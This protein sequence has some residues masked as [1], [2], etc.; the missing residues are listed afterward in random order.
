MSQRHRNEQPKPDLK[1]AADELEDLGEEGLYV[2]WLK[3]KEWW[4][5][6]GHWVLLAVLVV[7]SV[8]AGK[9]WLDV[10]A[11]RALEEYRVMVE[12][13]TDAMVLEQAARDTR[14][15]AHRA[16][17]FL[18]AGD[19][20]L[21]AAPFVPTTDD[22]R[23]AHDAALERALEAFRNVLETAGEDSAASHVAMMRMAVASERLGR[24]DD[25]R[26]WL[27]RLRDE[28]IALVN[29]ALA[30]AAERRLDLLDRLPRSVPVAAAHRVPMF[31]EEGTNIQSRHR[32]DAEHQVE[33]WEDPRL[34]I[35]GVMDWVA[36]T[37]PASSPNR[38]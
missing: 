4:S 25:A 21:A 23:A 36:P 13:E 12:N 15:P 8:W 26:G 28:R 29:P 10:R 14:R 37:L 3:V 33:V 32:L 17:L 1:L 2:H 22:E 35:P 18:R 20:H 38:D 34:P 31:P 7:V 24:Y 11:E 27:N 6:N 9:R 5:L 30:A 16:Q 19:R